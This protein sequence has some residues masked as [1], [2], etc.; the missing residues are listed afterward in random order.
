MSQA[1]CV[2]PIRIGAVLA[3]SLLFL[4]AISPA[5]GQIVK[6][7]P[8]YGQD[9]K[10]RQLDELLP[11][12]TGYRT[13]SGAPG[14][15][16][17]QQRAD[18]EIDV[19][20]D[21]E[22][23]RLIGKEKIAYTNN[24]PEPLRYIWLQLDQN[25]FRPGS[26]DAASATAPSLGRVSF[27]QLKSILA[28]RDF[29]GGCNLTACRT[30]DGEDLNHRVEGT[31][32]RIDLPTPLAQGETFTFVI[33]WNHNIINAGVIR[34]RGGYEHFE[35]DGN[36]I[37]EIAQWFPR[38]AV[39]NDEG[40]QLKPFVGTGE[41]ALEF[42]DYLVRITAPDDHVV[43]A[44]GVLLN[45]EAVLTEAQRERFERAKTAAKPVFVV[46]PDEAKE[47]EKT[48]PTGKKTWIFE[49]ENVRDF[50]FASSRKFIWDAWGCDVG[51]KLVMA[52]SLYP[53]EGEPLWSQ[54]S[55]QSIVHTLEVYSRY[56]FD[57]PYPTAY[58]VNGPV[59]GMEY[60]MICFNGPRPE[61]DGSYS[62]ATKYGLISVIIHEVGHNFF[63]MIV[64]SDE[65][66]WMW[67]DEGLNTFLQY[68]SEQE[69][70]EE[71]PSRRG[72]PQ[73]IVGFMRSRN[74]KPIM[75][76][77]DSVLQVGAN[78]YAKP[79]TAL[80]I[81]RESILGREVFD[82]AFKEYA[83][84]WKFKHPTPADL[85]RTM[86]DASGVDLDWFWRGWFYTTDH[87]DVAIDQVYV[88]RAKSGDPE[89][90]KRED[91]RERDAEPETL[92]AQRN[93]ML[94]KRTEEFPELKDFYN[95]Y[96][97]LDVTD[98]ER[99]SFQEM[100]EDLSDEEKSL[101]KTDS[102]FYVIELANRG[103]LVTPVVVQT[104]DVDGAKSEFTIPALI[105]RHNAQRVSKL[106]ISEKE[107]QSF[108]LD[109]YLQSADVD[110]A[111][112]VFPPEPVKS[113][114]ELFQG[115]PGTNPL[116]QAREAEEKKKKER[117]SH[118]SDDD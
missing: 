118:D 115:K 69:W 30:A 50:A 31:N 8:K 72:E 62:A 1:P 14:R 105:W 35:E 84:R 102:Y 106:I 32:L 66:E 42:G 17:W 19:E 20:L 79:A 33:E 2:S 98:A 96:D 73:D 27:D 90:D 4:A 49:A 61:E 78:A 85:F 24:S 28:R 94:P 80:N 99:E 6:A 13:A 86:E 110:L 21:D 60:P 91:R 103:G 97:P 65:R 7:D 22:K 100:L 59:Y 39:Y 40:W 44:S 11:T 88:Y 26:D 104:T 45:P 36:N 101:L 9:D 64:N 76:S 46:T 34:A 109:P 5:D 48:P 83:Q 25:R 56:T 52:M 3:A 87:V 23:Q 112:N 70:E 16:Y 43:G 63:P 117:E 89:I 93:A 82:E 77:A 15:A 107:I 67:M 57:Y 111:N 116:R 113:R 54:Y 71:Y 47:N 81:L 29:Q 55:T 18:Y 95:D 51:G 53:N 74:Q 108:R 92:S 75:T 58:S 41:F 37:Y 38:L 68:L 114:F 10:F 12:P